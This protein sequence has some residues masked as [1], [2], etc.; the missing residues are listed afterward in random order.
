MLDL[1]L[2][3]LSESSFEPLTKDPAFAELIEAG[4]KAA[5]S[6]AGENR[7]RVRRAG[8]AALSGEISKLRQLVAEVHRAR[9]EA[10]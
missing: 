4:D 10:R 9:G 3:R 2:A 6:L 5:A 7:A 8:D 1:L